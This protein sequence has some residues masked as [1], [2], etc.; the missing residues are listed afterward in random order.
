MWKPYQEAVKK[1]GTPAY[2]ECFGYVPL[3]ALGG[4]EKMENLQK[5]KLK[6]HILLI[7]A[8]AGPIQ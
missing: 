2:D 8:L 4:S 1:L 6:E 3:L 5:V 7:S